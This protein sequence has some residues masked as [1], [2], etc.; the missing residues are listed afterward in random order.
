MV[1]ENNGIIQN[2]SIFFISINSARIGLLPGIIKK[3]VKWIKGNI[4]P[5]LFTGMIRIIYLNGSFHH[6][7]KKKFV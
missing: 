1:S 4:N 6:I 2:A 5:S 7:S 3:Y